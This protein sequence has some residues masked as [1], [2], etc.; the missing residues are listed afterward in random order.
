MDC[1]IKTN[2]LILQSDV[3]IA[4]NKHASVYGTKKQKRYTTP[5]A[6]SIRKLWLQ[7]FPEKY[8]ISKRTVVGKIDRLLL[9]FKRKNVKE[10]PEEFIERHENLFDLVNQ[11]KVE[12][13]ESEEPKLYKFYQDQL[14]DRLNVISDPTGAKR[15]KENYS[16]KIEFIK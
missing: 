4:I 13:F 9:D 7:I 12:T 8:L 3:I 1:K 15:E 2:K 11:Y 10:S 14:G 16:V 5:L 6:K